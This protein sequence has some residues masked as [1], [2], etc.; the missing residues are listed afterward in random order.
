MEPQDEGFARHPSCRLQPWPI[1]RLA[2]AVAF[3]NC[4]ERTREC[5]RCA[6]WPWKICLHF[7]IGNDAWP[8]PANINVARGAPTC[9]DYL[10]SSVQWFCILAELM[11]FFCNP[12]GCGS[13]RRQR[14]VGVV[15]RFRGDSMWFLPVVRVC[16]TSAVERRGL[17]KRS[18]PQ[19]VLWKSVWLVPRRCDDDSEVGPIDN[20]RHWWWENSSMRSMPRCREFG[21]R[22]WIL[23]QWVIDG[24]CHMLWPILRRTEISW[25]W[26]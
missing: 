22:V 12:R 16:P 21:V 25:G 3:D 1:G 4:V 17:M 5:P 23:W 10:V 11:L 24:W 19:S 8:G 18:L 13:G 7:D 6:H 14:V 15:S 20:R 26:L 2:I 9:V